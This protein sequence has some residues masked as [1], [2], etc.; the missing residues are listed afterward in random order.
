MIRSAGMRTVGWSVDTHDWKGLGRED[1][2]RNSKERIAPGGIALL[3]DVPASETVEEDVT[4]GYIAKEDLTGVLL[5]ELRSRGMTAVSLQQL[6]SAG[7][8]LRRAKLA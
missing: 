3:H 2:L 1:P 7:P 8:T 6:I 4:R 5:E